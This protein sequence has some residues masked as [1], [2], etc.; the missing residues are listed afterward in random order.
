MQVRGVFVQ[1]L[2]QVGSWPMRPRKS[3]QQGEHYTAAHLKR[4]LPSRAY[5]FQF[6]RCR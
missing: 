1:Q 2:A 3:Q 6:E 4:R 5:H